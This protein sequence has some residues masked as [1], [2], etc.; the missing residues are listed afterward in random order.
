MSK[1]AA[2]IGDMHVCPMVTPGVPPIPHV[3]GPVIGPG[4]PTVLIGGMPAAVMGDMCTCVGPPDSI[5]LGSTGVMIGNKPAARMGD[6]CAHGGSIVVGCPTVLIGEMSPGSPPPPPVIKMIMGESSNLTS[7]MSQKTAQVVALKRAAES[8]AP[9]CEKCEAAR[10][11]KK[12]AEEKKTEEPEKDY[13]R[14]HW[15][16]LRVVSAPDESPRPSWWPQRNPAPFAGVECD[17][18]LSDGAQ[19]SGKLTSSSDVIV[20]EVESGTFSVNLFGVSHGI[21]VLASEYGIG[22]PPARRPSPGSAPFEG[23][24]PS[25]TEPKVREVTRKDLGAPLKDLATDVSHEI[26]VKREIIPIIFVPGVMGS[27]LRVS[28]A[29]AGRKED[30]SLPLLRWNPSSELWLGWHFF[31][32]FPTHRVKMLIGQRGFSEDYLTVN[33]VEERGWDGI[34]SGYHKFLAPLRDHDWGRLGRVFEFPVIAFGYNWTASN[35]TSAHKLADR[36]KKAIEDAEKVAGKGNCPGVILVTH[37]MGGLVARACCK[38]N[39]VT[40]KVLGVVHGVMPANGSPS[41][42]WRIKCGI[43]HNS[44]EDWVASRILGA[45]AEEV[46][47]ILAGTAGPLQLLP[48]RLYTTNNSEPAWLRTPSFPGVPG[49]EYPKSNPYSEIYRKP[50]YPDSSDSYWRLVDPALLDPCE[51]NRGGLTGSCAEIDEPAAG[52]SPSAWSRYLATIKIAEDFHAWLGDYSHPRTISLAGTGHK[53]ADVAE[54]RAVA[55]SVYRNRW[56]KLFRNDRTPYHNEGY[57]PGFT[58]RDGDA[59]VAELEV[60]SGD[61]DGTVPVSSATAL[62]GRL[63]GKLNPMD[64]KIPAKHQPS[65]EDSDFRRH[66]IKSIEALATLYCMEGP[67]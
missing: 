61:G 41:A 57:T 59:F 39:K 33:S 2:R 43:E 9:F 37:S 3:G 27:V 38:L 19:E 30:A 15:F 51:G 44:A 16:V 46:T 48:N 35:K 66:A 52:G 42:Y 64:A 25:E 14:S 28:D 8:G 67:P 1:P 29:H 12:K 55:A 54:Y 23:Y 6:M 34:H 11:A 60:P 32:R 21:E 4:C 36:I 7:D 10:K 22:K 47:P 13:V 65:Y 45:N 56:S 53:S 18:T 50:A 62:F 20:T 17:V 40:D 58:N 49:E 63:K 24:V 31:N 5:V 26:R